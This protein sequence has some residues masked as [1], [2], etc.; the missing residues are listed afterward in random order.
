MRILKML[1]LADAFFTKDQS[2]HGIMSNYQEMFK[3][4]YVGNALL[5]YSLIFVCELVFFVPLQKV[6]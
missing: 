5:I 3:L 2:S 1:A 6:S 4:S